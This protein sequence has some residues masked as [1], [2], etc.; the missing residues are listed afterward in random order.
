MFDGLLNLLPI[1]AV[2]TQR[3]LFLGAFDPSESQHLPF[4]FRF[5]LVPPY[6]SHLNVSIQRFFAFTMLFRS[7]QHLETCFY[8]SSKMYRKYVL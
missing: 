2:L 1:N 6:L 7:L 3:V 8:N 5:V 4:M